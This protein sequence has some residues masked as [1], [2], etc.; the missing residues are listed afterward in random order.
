MIW[1]HETTKHAHW[2]QMC[3]KLLYDSTFSSLCS[4]FVA[5][6]G[7]I[8]MWSFVEKHSTLNFA[9]QCL[10]WRTFK[11]WIAQCDFLCRE[12]IFEFLLHC[13]VWLENRNEMILQFSLIKFRNNGQFFFQILY[14]LNLT[15]KKFKKSKTVKNYFL[16]KAFLIY[17]N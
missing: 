12:M 4:A 14:Q 9:P 6:I 17:G 2:L 5:W 1:K 8:C 15:R 10:T 16:I 7:N 3:L 11:H 13:N